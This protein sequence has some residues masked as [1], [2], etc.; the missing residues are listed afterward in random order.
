MKAKTKLILAAAILFF[1]CALLTACQREEL[2][3]YSTFAYFGS[4]TVWAFSGEGE[5][6]WRKIGERAAQIEESVSLSKEGALTRF[7]NAKAGERVELDETAFA[8]F[9]LAEELHEKTNGAYDPS[10]GNL[11]DLWGFSPRCVA[12][13][14]IP[15][16]PYDRAF[17]EELPSAEY[18]A[19]F[20]SLCHYP[21]VRLEREE[22][23]YFAYKP[24]CTAEV[25]GVEYCVKLD[26]GGLG[27]GYC[28]DECKKIIGE[29]AAGY[30]SFGG[31]S[32][33]LF[34]NPADEAGFDLG[35][36]DPRGSGT[37]LHI[38]AKNTAVST[39]GDY[40]NYYELGGRRYCH[41]IDPATGF[42]VGTAS[43]EEG[44]ILS[45]TVLS[46]SAAEG[47]ALS[48]AII[49]MGRERAISFIKER[50]LSALFLYSDG[51]NET[52]YISLPENSY[53]LDRRVEVVPL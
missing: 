23:K 29:G 51:E 20:S 14:Y 22:G 46:D 7:N 17:A 36:I 26:F 5:E 45:A 2:S 35:V 39:S 12:A 21:E 48:T 38:K 19:A 13:D 49:V 37:L 40:M 44:H 27:K 30:L 52:L 1:D 41:I 47:D 28:A 24:D 8:L 16:A 34:E 10:V 18:L 33:I 42:P 11:S 6:N 31:S 25:E 50:A 32:L 53:S 9:S 3:A 15:A 4:E 43:G